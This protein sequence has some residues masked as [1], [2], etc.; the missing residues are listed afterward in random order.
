MSAT[1]MTQTDLAARARV[2][3]RWLSDLESGK[4]TAEIGL[5]L[6]VVDADP[7]AWHMATGG[8]FSRAGAQAK[9]ALYRDRASDLPARLAEKIGEHAERCR[10]ALAE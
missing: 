1:G 7:S 2:S 5:V 8:Q 3:R 4:P 9:T 6:K 10:L